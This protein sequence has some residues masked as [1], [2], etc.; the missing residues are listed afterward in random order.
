M[1]LMA[2]TP[3]AR[4]TMRPSTRFKMKALLH[5]LIFGSLLI[6]LYISAWIIKYRDF[7]FS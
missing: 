5:G 3:Q 2:M 4:A 6:T 1:A 7:F